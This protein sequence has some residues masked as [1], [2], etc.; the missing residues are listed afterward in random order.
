VVNFEMKIPEPDFVAPSSL[1]F[2]VLRM[3][4]NVKLCIAGALLGALLDEVSS[5]DSPSGFVES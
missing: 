1:F 4:K 2:E 3:Q 5:V